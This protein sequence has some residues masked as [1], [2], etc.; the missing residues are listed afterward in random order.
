MHATS[1]RR[2]GAC[3]GMNEVVAIA[4][5]R[6]SIDVKLVVIADEEVWQHN[7]SDIKLMLP[8]LHKSRIALLWMQAA[9]SPKGHVEILRRVLC[10]LL[11]YELLLP[12]GHLMQEFVKRLDIDA[13]HD[14]PLEAKLVV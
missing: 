3:R 14:H 4:G 6:A 5:V 7:L 10:E 12:L 8:A 9:D 13:L 2:T 1:W 11:Y